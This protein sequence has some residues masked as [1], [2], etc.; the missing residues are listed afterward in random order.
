MR[1]GSLNSLELQSDRPLYI[2]SDGEIYAGM[3]STV[4]HLQI[5]TFA[6][7]ILAVAPGFKE[8]ISSRTPNC[9]TYGV[10]CI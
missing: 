4:N 7:A 9:I 2:H 10:N 6:G 8:E 5:E 1:T 3:H